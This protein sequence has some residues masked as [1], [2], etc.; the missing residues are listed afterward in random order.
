MEV[1]GF[2]GFHSIDNMTVIA[3]KQH[4]RASSASKT[5]IAIRLT[6]SQDGFSNIVISRRNLPACLRAL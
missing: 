6:C 4:T 3:L 5:I 1:I 2:R